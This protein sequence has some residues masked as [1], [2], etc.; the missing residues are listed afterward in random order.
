MW[1]LSLK[2]S[3]DISNIFGIKGSNKFGGEREGFI[4]KKLITKK[5]FSQNINIHIDLLVGETFLLVFLFFDCLFDIEY[6]M[7]LLFQLLFLLFQNVYLILIFWDTFQQFAVD[8]LS[9]NKL[10]YK[11]IDPPYCC[12]L[13]YISETG[14]N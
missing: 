4:F 6:I 11:L 2:S 14:F 8:L 3:F 9:F 12:V 7:M 1:L 5:S 13:L 10:L